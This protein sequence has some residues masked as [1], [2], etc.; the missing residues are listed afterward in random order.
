MKM[1]AQNN[2]VNKEKIEKKVTKATSVPTAIT[3][4]TK[5]ERDL[6]DD[7]DDLET[8]II[9]RPSGRVE[10]KLERSSTF[11]KEVSDLPAGELQVID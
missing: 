7:G 9:I 4:S 8:D 6:Y 5:N 2:K 10:S 1:V 3:K 11:C